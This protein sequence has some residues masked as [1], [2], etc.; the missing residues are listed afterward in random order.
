[1]KLNG[2]TP[3]ALKLIKELTDSGN[4]IDVYDRE[5]VKANPHSIFIN[6]KMMDEFDKE[7][8]TKYHHHLLAIFVDD[9]VS[10]K[11]L[12]NVYP[13]FAEC[14]NE[15]VFEPH[16]IF[17]NLAT[18]QIAAYTISRKGGFHSKFI[19]HLENADWE[20]QDE[21]FRSL[22]FADFITQLRD[23]LE[24]IPN[25]DYNLVYREIDS[26]HVQDMLA[27]GPNVNGLYYKDSWDNDDEDEFGITQEELDS[28]IEEIEDLEADLKFA[29]EIF[30]NEF[31]SRA[32]SYDNF[33]ID[34]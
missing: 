23:T 10:G 3:A 27:R 30:A 22:D 14:F 31:P 20:D 25:A 5:R 26:G 2:G 29:V 18:K 24:I 7:H 19:P 1:M 28:A 17:I 6:L 12:I 4:L 21:L 11:E 8:G 33:A 15:K 32:I 9:E 16:L 13:P 34:D